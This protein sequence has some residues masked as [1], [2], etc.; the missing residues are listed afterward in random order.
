MLRI[1]LPYVMGNV[2]GSYRDKLSGAYN[3]SVC[4]PWHLSRDLPA[5][6]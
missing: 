1:L 5:P 2:T 3:V 4:F 6:S